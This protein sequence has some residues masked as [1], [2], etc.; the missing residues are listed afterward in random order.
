MPFQYFLFHWI[1]LQQLF[2]TLAI[3]RYLNNPHA[4]LVNAACP[5]P[6][7]VSDR[8]SDK[9]LPTNLNSVLPVPLSREPF[10]VL[11]SS[12]GRDRS[13]VYVRMSNALNKI[14]FILLATWGV[15]RA[16]TPPNPPPPQHERLPSL[17]VPLENYGLISWAPFIGRV[18]NY[19]EDILAEI[20]NKQTS[21]R[22][23]N[24]FFALLR[25]QLFWHMQTLHRLYPN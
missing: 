15:H 17:A 1:A 22:S 13:P 16:Y 7:D 5:M 12:L 10:R 24:S 18:S 21:V 8:R 4:N 9:G 20:F 19:S 6:S 11:V 25:Y 14:P 3:E 2:S 23:H